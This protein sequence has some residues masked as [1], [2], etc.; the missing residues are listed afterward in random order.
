MP[1][2]STSLCM[3]SGPGALSLLKN[4]TNL[5]SELR[6]TFFTSSLYVK[7]STI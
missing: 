3:M 4:L 7:S 5:M 6:L 2:L 1:S